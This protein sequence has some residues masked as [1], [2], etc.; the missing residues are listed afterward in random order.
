[1]NQTISYYNEHAEEFCNDTVDVDFHGTE[2]HFLS[3]LPRYARI[4][5][6]GCGSGR[7][8]VYFR[9]KGYRAEGVDGSDEI[10]HYASKYTGTQIRKMLFSDLNDVQSF[11]GIW[12]AASILH[13]SQ[14]NMPKVLYKMADALVEGGFIYASFKYG[15]NEEYREGR[16]YNDM[17]ERKFRKVLA[18]VPTLQLKE[19]WISSDVKKGHEDDRWLNVIM[20]KLEDPDR[21]PHVIS[22][23]QSQKKQFNQTVYTAESA[24]H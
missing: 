11:D 19:V 20:Q 4:L 24:V 7:D 1:M 22:Y 9:K 21:I 6:F 15:E 13:V 14:K 23:S 8:I 2:D 16:F 5:D 12:A 17:T 10:C 18:T 3:L